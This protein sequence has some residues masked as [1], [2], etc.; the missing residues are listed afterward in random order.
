MTETRIG[1]RSLRSAKLPVESGKE[2]QPINPENIS[3][4]KSLLCR[5]K[6]R[7][8]SYGTCTL[9]RQ[10]TYHSE[11]ERQAVMRVPPL[12]FPRAVS[13]PCKPECRFRRYHLLPKLNNQFIL[14]SLKFYG[15]GLYGFGF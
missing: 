15:F 4:S 12:R 7:R 1:F 9:C 10:G 5:S 13:L 8:D 6:C 2:K 14:K 11:R 3:H